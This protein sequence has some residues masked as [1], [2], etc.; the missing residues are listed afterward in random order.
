MDTEFE[1]FDHFLNLIGVNK[2]VLSV[3]IGKNITYVS[4]VHKNRSELPS[5]I[6]SFLEERYSLNRQWLTH[7]IGQPLIVK[8]QTLSQK[9][10]LCFKCTNR[11]FSNLLVVRGNN[12]HE[13]C[14]I[15]KRCAYCRE[16]G[17]VYQKNLCKKCLMSRLSEVRN[18]MNESHALATR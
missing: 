18:I 14:Y 5:S 3:M 15:G 17:P 6:V 7:G 10:V 2:R 13:Y 8:D 16:V 4:K 9:I 1:R 11:I 12:Y